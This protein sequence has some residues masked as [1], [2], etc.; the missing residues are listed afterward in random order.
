MTARE[1]AKIEG[2]TD[3][4]IPR[5]DLIL[6]DEFLTI[7]R[8]VTVQEDAAKRSMNRILA[9]VDE[10][11]R[12]NRWEDIIALV[13]PAEEKVPELFP[14]GLEVRVREKAAFALGQIGQFDQA[15]TELEE[16]LKK[17]PDSF[18]LH[19]ALAYT[20]YNSLFA[21]QRRTVF[22][23]GK[24]RADRVELAHRHFEAAQTLR[25]EGVTNFY[26]RGMLFRKIEN[27]TSRALP[28]FEKA[29]SN[30]DAYTAEQQ[31]LRSQERKN[32]IKALYQSASSLLE[33]DKPRQALVQLRRCL[34]E[35][36][37]SNVLSMVFKYFALGKIHR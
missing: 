34:S 24:A 32:F 2:Q 11:M 27:K 8:L 6:G 19:S 31:T 29:V 10:L 15:I 3:R 5:E 9:E 1:L 23:S 16:S 17:E 14:H 37:Q 22:L 13:H 30:W 35:D 21:A 4:G 7:D 25:P 20:A 12:E 26:R 28:F 18:H 36:E 33:L